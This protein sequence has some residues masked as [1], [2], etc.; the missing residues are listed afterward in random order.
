MRDCVRALKG[1]NNSLRTGQFLK[2]FKHFL[3]SDGYI[4]RPAYHLQ[5]TVLRSNTRVV[6]P[7]RNRIGLLR[8]A[9][10]IQQH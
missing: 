5:M 8:L 2:R 10:L 4:F 3:V 9:L 6:E 7:R 1:W